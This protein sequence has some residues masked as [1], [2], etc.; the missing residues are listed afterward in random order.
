MNTSG[1]LLFQ[2]IYNLSKGPSEVD[3]LRPWLVN[4]QARAPNCPVIVV[5]THKDMVQRGMI[6]KLI[7][8][9]EWQHKSIIPFNGIPTDGR[10]LS[11]TTASYVTRNTHMFFCYSDMIDDLLV[12]KN[13]VWPLKVE[14]LFIDAAKYFKCS[15][16]PKKVSH[17]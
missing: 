7:R 3:M 5:G 13:H 16:A 12:L 8:Y 17:S 6:V 1:S 2:V 9:T 11:H 15:K 4:I 14:L 10:A